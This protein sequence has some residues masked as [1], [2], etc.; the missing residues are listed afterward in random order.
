VVARGDVWL[1]ALDP[2]IGSEIQKTRPCVVVSPAELHDHL[3][4]VIVAPMTTA[5][6][7]AP[8]RVPLTFLRKKGLILLDQIRTVDKTRLVKR[9]GAVSD[10]ALSNALST[11]QEIFVE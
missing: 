9:A 10:T 6:R 11:L 8:F 7:A 4:T 1:V 5:G 2:T 3:S